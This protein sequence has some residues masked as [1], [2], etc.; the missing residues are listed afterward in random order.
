M[1]RLTIAFLSLFLFVGVQVNAHVPFLK[2]NQFIVLHNR[3][4]IESS[5]TEFP[6]QAD[7]AM[8][9]PCFSMIEPGGGQTIL[10]PTAKTRVANYLEPRLAG[11]GTYR[12]NAGVRKGPKYKAL[13]T[14]DGKLYFSDDM[15]K[16]QGRATSL[17]YYSSADTYLAKGQPDYKPQL[18]EKGIEIIPL[19]SPNAIQVKD[20]SSFR[21]Y[22][23]GKPVANA[24]VVVV[25]DNE[26]YDKHRIGDLYDVENTRES[27]L[28]A[29][30]DGVFTFS[31]KKAGLVLLFVTVHT[32][33][34]DTLWESYNSSLS[35]EVNLPGA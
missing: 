18:M 3:L 19:S 35:L 30:A 13:E 10:Q 23:D 21:V 1:K 34:D 12:I 15:Q 17:Q 16:H 14:P 31:P 26:H 7:F 6:F 24:R 8:D 28:N 11:D 32:K 20:E 27:T 5:F 2:P 4:Q 9:S 22:Q 33:I 25:Y 29:N